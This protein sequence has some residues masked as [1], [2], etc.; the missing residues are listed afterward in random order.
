[1]SE[2]NRSIA[3]LR[4]DGTKESELSITGLSLFFSLAQ[5]GRRL[6]R[7]NPMGPNRDIWVHDLDRGTASRLTYGNNDSNPVWTSDGKRIAYSSGLPKPNL[8]WR[9]ADG[10]GPEE[11]LSTSSNDQYPNAFSPD[12]KLLLYSELD[13]SS[14]SDIWVLPLEGDRKPWA[15]LKTPYSEGYGVFSPDGKWLA[16]QSNES[17]RYEIFVQ[18]FPAG[19][20][21]WQVSTEGGQVPHWSRDGRSLFYRNRNAVMAVSMQLEGGVVAKPKTLFEGAYEIVY[22]VAPDGR[23]VMNPTTKEGAITQMSLV[24]NWR[25]ELGRQLK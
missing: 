6:A 13:P 23:F 25:D 22:A 17:G 19:G 2:G 16:Y 4:P 21:K 3:F 20:R 12:G 7:S 18:P 8:H 11:R 10:S 24:V 1:M 15:F 14:G 5:D 9:L